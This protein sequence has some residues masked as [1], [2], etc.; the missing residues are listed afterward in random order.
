MQ[1][2][3]LYLKR[4]QRMFSLKQTAVAVLALGS[5]TLFAGAMGPVCTPGNVTVPCAR[6]AWDIGAQALYLQTVYDAAWSYYDNSVFTGV[7]GSYYNDN[8]NWNW[9]FQIEGS[10]H[11]NTGNDINVNWYHLDTNTD[12]DDNLYYSYNFLRNHWDAVNAEFGQLIDL[13]PVSRM[14]FH[15]GVQFARIKT[16][17]DNNFV[18]YNGLYS[19]YNGVGPR[20][21]ID[22]NYGFGNGFG[23]YAKGATAVL[24]GTSKFN[25]PTVVVSGIGSGYA[26]WN[27]IVPEV[28]AKLG[29]NYTYAMA[30][31]DLTLDAGYMWFNYFNALSNPAFD[32]SG[33]IAETNF[34]AS[35]PYLGLK[36]VG[37][38]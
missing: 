26:S 27:A 36:Y 15:G 29:V 7:P 38:V 9:G 2:T 32:I 12:N 14:R 33:S 16:D 8:N 6:T 3:Q 20:A 23:I 1:E 11:F 28:E 37:N 18:T 17:T 19:Q 24:V 13:S 5:S 30:Q 25:D 22:M 4:R 34:A 10:Y 35:G 31:G 21:G